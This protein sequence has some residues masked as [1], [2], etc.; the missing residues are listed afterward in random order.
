MHH[1]TSHITAFTTAFTTSRG[2]LAGMRNSS[3]GLPW[4]IDPTTHRTMSERS[5]HGATNWLQQHGN[6]WRVA[7]HM[8]QTPQLTRIAWVSVVAFLWWL[9]LSTVVACAVFGYS[10]GKFLPPPPIK[11]TIVAFGLCVLYWLK[12]QLVL[13][14]LGNFSFYSGKVSFGLQYNC[15]T[16]E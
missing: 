13:Q 4:R 1:P 8:Y 12:F 2:A 16:E 14:C 15:V 9:F 3:M 10:W 6:N 7:H 11:K 5:Y